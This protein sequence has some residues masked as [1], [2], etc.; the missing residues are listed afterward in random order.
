[1]HY[2]TN[3]VYYKLCPWTLFSLNGTYCDKYNYS[4]N[5]LKIWK[6]VPLLMKKEWWSVL[7]RT[8][9]AR[10]SKIKRLNNFYPKQLD[11]QI[12]VR[13]L[14]TETQHCLIIQSCVFISGVLM[15][16]RRFFWRFLLGVAPEDT[17]KNQG[18]KDLEEKVE[19]RE[20]EIR[21]DEVRLKGHL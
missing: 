5:I 20:K 17:D 8:L 1:M 2:I 13:R 6:W 9:S 15:I 7:Y 16:Q 11:M 14:H 21:A 18:F 19:E 3:L 10:K 4:E 12:S